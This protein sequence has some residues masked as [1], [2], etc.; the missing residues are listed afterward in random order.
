MEH[1]QHEKSQLLLQ[2]KEKIITAK[3]GKRN[4][5]INNHT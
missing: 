4:H 3:T 2:N 5:D 1:R